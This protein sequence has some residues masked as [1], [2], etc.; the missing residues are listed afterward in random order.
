MRN[1]AIWGASR[2]GSTI[3]ESFIAHKNDILALGEVKNYFKRG[4]QLNERCSCGHNAAECTIWASFSN[5]DYN[6][7][8]SLYTSL[9]KLGEGYVDSSKSPFHLV[10]Y[11]KYFSEHVLI[12]RQ[13]S[14][15]IKSYRKNKERPESTGSRTKMRKMI[16][17]MSLT[18]WCTWNLISLILMPKGSVVFY[19]E[20]TLKAQGQV[21]DQSKIHQISGNPSRFEKLGVKADEHKSNNFD[22]LMKIILKRLAILLGHDVEY[23]L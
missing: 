15:V 11:K 4:Q 3:F 23:R 9:Q 5:V 14:A 19:D 6:D 18:Y 16:P 17:P 10:K 13:P 12:I 22:K 7:F 8:D 2:S 1:I 21:Y 20:F